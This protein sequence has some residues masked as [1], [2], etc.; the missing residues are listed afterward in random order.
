MFA[1]IIGV[2]DALTVPGAMEACTRTITKELAACG[3]RVSGGCAVG[4]NV[5]QL[6]ATIARALERSDVVL[7]IGGLGMGA[8]GITKNTVC[9]GLN[10]R[11]VLH[12]DSLRRIRAAY[13]HAGRQ[14]PQQ[15]TRL[16]MLPEKSIIFPGVKGITPGCALAAGN[17]FIIMLPEKP[18]EHVPMLQKSVVPYLA[19]FA[20]AAVVTHTI[21]AFGITEA[22][23]RSQLGSLLNS[24]EPSVALYAKKGEIQV[25]VTARAGDKAKAAAMVNPVVKAVREALGDRV[26][27]VDVRD[28]PHTMVELMEARRLDLSIGEGGTGGILAQLLMEHVPGGS[29]L[30]RFH[31]S[32]TSQKLKTDA[33]KVPPKLLKR[34]GA[35]S[36]Q[37]AAA[38]AY[39]AMLQGGSNVGLA[40]TGNLGNQGDDPKHPGLCYVALCTERL[41]WV[42]R[43][44]LS[45]S[46]SPQQQRYLVC[47][48]ALDLA[49]RYAGALPG[50]LPGGNPLKAVMSGKV[51]VMSEELALARPVKTKRPFIAAVLP[52]KGD[53]AVDVI[54][55]LI[56]IIAVVVFIS[57]IS[58]LVNFKMQS[59][60]NKATYDKVAESY[61]GDISDEE[62][63]TLKQNGEY[64]ADYQAKFAALYQQNPEVAGW[65]QIEGTTI[66]YP[67]VQT[68][69]NEYYLRRDFTKQSSKYGT[70]WLDAYDSMNPQCDNYVIYGHNMT[71][72]QMFGELMKYK[73]SGEGLTFLQQHPIIQMDDVY[74]DN[75]YKIVSVFITNAIDQYGPVFYYNDY[76]D[77]SDQAKFNEFVEEIT[78]RSYYTSDVDIQY[79]DKFVTLSTC[80]YEYGPVSENAHVRTVIV[81]RRVRDGEEVDPGSITY[82][83]NPNPKMPVG[84]TN[85]NSNAALASSA[86]AAASS[87][88]AASSQEQA[89]QSSEEQIFNSQTL[90]DTVTSSQTQSSSSTASSSSSGSSSNRGESDLKENEAEAWEQAE[91]AQ[92]AQ[93]RA[94]RAL[95]DAK[96]AQRQAEKTD[97]AEE[98]RRAADKAASAVDEAKE[99]YYEALD[100]LDAA[101]AAYEQ[102]PTNEAR[103][104]LSAAESAVDATEQA[105]DSAKEYADSADEIASNLGTGSSSSSSSSSSDASSSSS[106]SSSSQAESSSSSS[107]SQAS[108]SEAS[109]SETSSEQQSSSDG[110]SSSGS[111][112]ADGETMGGN[113]FGD[114]DTHEVTMERP[115]ISTMQK[116]QGTPNQIPSVSSS[117]DEEEQ[118]EDEVEDEE[119][120]EDNG[121]S[122]VD[123]GQLTISTNGSRLTGD[124]EEIVAKVVMNEM[125]D[126]FQEEALKA[127]AVAVYTYV[128]YENNYGRTPALG[129]K[130]PS[131]KVRNAVDQVIGQ[132]VYYN[133]NLAYTPFF[134]TSAGVTLASKDVWGG[135]YPYLVSVDSEVDQD[136]SSYE[137]TVAWDEDKL[138]TQVEKKLDVSLDGDPEDW[139]EIEEYIDDTPYVRSIRVGDE[140]VSGRTFRESVLGL[141]SAAFDVEYD[142]DEEAFHFTT[143]G[144]GH[145]VGMSQMGAQLYA[146][147]GWDYIDILEHY[148]EGAYVD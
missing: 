120:E 121:G 122:D 105:W 23:A 18:A 70:P 93:K 66:N 96:D 39:G 56:L 127:Q 90:S 99:A 142:A 83:I 126:S 60:G 86:A 144:Y 1:E 106:S 12:E 71:D 2:G 115:T 68:D 53:G 137:R 89:Q 41:A 31:A 15:A 147:Q 75:T 141:R 5:Q 123:A 102:N 148:Y 46:E 45:P 117:D 95:S 48:H 87:E 22:Q 17:Q 36:P 76:Q 109:S 19:Q 63:D 135:S 98:A 52:W 119:D 32:A 28:L 104:A 108:S 40:I 128:K 97:S 25:R 133:G 114:R 129:A 59:A 107:S 33:L 27:G 111:D 84:F 69:N 103:R 82:G 51:S 54:R 143:Y 34:F 130:S 42:Q 139:L 11:L 81:G 72:G 29:D 80:S 118:E 47:L 61:R 4:V 10:R 16:A 3:V 13:E 92:A 6:R 125:G 43:V 131:S 67:V 7:L 49:R 37:T 78:A 91:Q 57:S 44:D 88:A 110:E 138:V 38:M 132:A 100:A 35:V 21:N 65:V 58:Y 50:E 146:Q 94:E 74:R 79:G 134:S 116:P 8:D 77:M 30:V 64:P 124:A 73:P 24:K 145:G 55:K 140:T 85:Q 20:N 136:A 113:P 9:E 14:M 62:V 112:Q 26:Y 101:Q